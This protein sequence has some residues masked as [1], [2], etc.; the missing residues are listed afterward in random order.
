TIATD[1]A[2]LRGRFAH[3]LGERLG[4]PPDR[5]DAALYAHQGAAALRHVFAVASALDSLV[6][7]EPH[8]LGQLR[9]AHR[10][11]GEA[12]LLGPALESS[13][14]AAYASARRVRRETRIA[15]RPVSIA[16]AAV[17]LAREIH[18]DLDRLTALVLGTAEMG[19]LMA[20][21]FRNAGVRRL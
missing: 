14:Q 12:G 20:E 18:G 1:L 10:A 7:G 13:L 17:E 8:V 3:Y 19:E 9:A 16:A 5:I 15:E 4:E 11:A 2:A 21:H 6:I